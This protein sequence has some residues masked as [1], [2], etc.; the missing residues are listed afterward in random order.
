MIGED[1]MTSQNK[2][3]FTGVEW[4]FPTIQ[5]TWDVIDKIGK[6]VFHLDYYAP[7]IEIITA[8]Q[9]LDA[10]SSA[11]MPIMYNHWSFGKSFIESERAY[12]AGQ[13]GLAYEVVINTNPSIAYLMESN[14]MA[15]QTLVMAHAVCGHGSFFKNNYMFKEWTDADGILSY[16]K[17]AK[18]Y[19]ADC[20]EKY[21]EGN[22]TQLLDACHALRFHGHDSCKHTR[23]SK[24]SLNKR[25]SLW[26][27]YDDETVNVLWSTVA[28]KSEYE[29]RFQSFIS[30]Q[31]LKRDNKRYL[32][33]DNILY[34]LEK[35]SRVLKPWQREVIRIVRNINQ[36]F[37]PQRQTQL[38]NEGMATF[39]HYNIMREMHDQGYITDG[40]YL[41]ML[42]SH[43]GVIAQLP[44]DSKWYQGLNVYAVGFAMF[45]DIRRICESPT[46]EDKRLFRDIAGSDWKTTINEIVENF[47]DESFLLQFLS[48]R[49]VQQL[50]LSV[51][52]NNSADD[53]VELKYA[54]SRLDEIRHYYSEQSKISN[55]IPQLSIEQVLER[56]NDTL[57]VF[58][59]PRN[60]KLLDVESVKQY[61]KIIQFLWGRPV[62]IF[63]K[64]PK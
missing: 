55:R 20:E 32:P 57:T 60:G 13:M 29:R 49:V 42:H 44:F 1:C 31:R 26:E 52:T 58:Y 53:Y 36:Y 27:E 6:E 22:V 63:S 33:E 19:I 3:L 28:S 34:F 25:V 16:L 9:M 35:H 64:E 48:P 41:E 5:K 47:R 11:A 2:P 50:G 30:Q 59:T 4:D 51:M 21:G 46:E 40:A 62:T 23:H 14:T 7:Q 56:E 18:M 8:E 43:S 39:T 38:M 37:Y 15:M 24:E 17:Y 61:E 45:Q 54:Q 10:Y 12:R